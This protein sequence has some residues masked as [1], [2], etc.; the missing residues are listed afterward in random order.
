[1]RFTVFVLALLLVM[2]VLA[3]VSLLLPFALR[4]LN[5]T[6]KLGEVASQDLRAPAKAEFV[7]E[8][9]TEQERDRV[10]RE[11][12]PVYSPPDEPI[13]REQLELLREALSRI[14]QIRSDQTLP[15]TEKQAAIAGV[16]GLQLPPDVTAALVNLSDARWNLIEQEA[17]RV[18]EQAMREP[19]HDDTVESVRS[20]LAS[21][22]TLALSGEQA[23]LVAQLVSPFVIPNSFYSPELTDQARQ[24]ARDGVDP[25]TRTFLPG[26]IIVQRG[27]VIDEGDLEALAKVGLAQQQPGWKDYAGAAALVLVL[28]AFVVMYF[29]RRRPAL[30]RDSRG[31]LVLGIV[32][33]AFLIG[34]RLVIPGRTVVPYVY[35]LPAFALIVTALFGVE[36]A[37]V[38]S[39][40]LSLLAPYGLATSEDL[41]IFYLLASVCGALALLPARRVGH[42]LRA[43]GVIFLAAAAVLAA[44]RV[45]FTPWDWAGLATLAGASLLNG[46]AS[47]SLALLVQFFAA[48]FLGFTTALHLLEVSRPDHPLLQYLLRT[49]PG[50]YQHSLMVANLAEQAADAIGADSL[51]VRVGA[52]Y[53]DSGKAANPQFFIEN[54]SPDR[55][56]PHDDMDPY[57]AAR[58]VIKHIPDGLAMARRHR[59]PDRVR[60][61]I[62]EHHGTL[63]TRYQY[64][65]AVEA[66]GGDSSQVDIEKF[67]YPGPAPRS[68]ETAILMIADM[69]EA[70][71]RSERPQDEEGLRASIQ[72]S[73]DICQQ[74]GQLDDTKLTLSDLHL[75]AQ[76]LAAGLQGSYHPRI[77]YP[78]AEQVP[79]VQVQPK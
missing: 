61:F 69:T 28:V 67:R 16:Q 42:F 26:Q 52:L 78:S 57:E 2:G 36:P 5:L 13:A 30:A 24:D 39:I 29:W 25:V 64:S 62:S 77:A 58:L 18:L 68:R 3:F 33:A 56:D 8:V 38:L 1:V 9:L 48:Q 75:I 35:P 55:L 19:I 7:S 43:G 44:Y 59:L 63:I 53:H 76:S 4:N 12:S 51:M 50:T 41:F 73:I 71:V 70:R 15:F 34:A 11:V 46:V 47:A 20:S 65:R 21:K 14:E 49:A 60:D 40:P 32:F 66:A 27:T 72:R 23:Q 10:E 74:N 22:V 31:M 17:L 37:I 79:L 54:Q 6:V 45:P